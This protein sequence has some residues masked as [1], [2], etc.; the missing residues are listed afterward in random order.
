MSHMA[1]RC[2]LSESYPRFRTWII[3]RVLQGA[4]PKEVAS[5]LAKYRSKYSG[6][7]RMGWAD[8]LPEIPTEAEIERLRAAD[9]WA[10]LSP[11]VASPGITPP[12]PGRPH[13]APHLAERCHALP[14]L[15]GRYPA[16][17]PT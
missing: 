14:D 3:S 10:A 9:T 2:R 8:G 4:T 11:R 5:Y 12:N 13:R 7:T 6:T 15:T 16:P 1:G 17:R